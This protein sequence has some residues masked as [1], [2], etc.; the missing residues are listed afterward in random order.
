MN[1]TN[2]LTVMTALSL[3][4]SATS[5]Q[6]ANIQIPSL[7]F[8]ITSAGTYVLKGNLSYSGTS[9]AI[10]ISPNITGPVILNLNGFTITGIVSLV[11]VPVKNFSVAVGVLGAGT[12]VP[13]I[14][15]EN[16]V[17]Q[18][19]GFGLWVETGSVLSNINVNNMAFKFILSATADGV[20]ILFDEVN[21]S[22]VTNCTFTSSDKGIADGRSGGGN[23]YTNDSFTNDLDC[24]DISPGVATTV[25]NHCQVEEPSK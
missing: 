21:S 13:S 25:I 4:M 10:N 18:N 8:N 12:L 1:R 24:L 22:S 3:I 14:T 2:S 5:L 20:C 17:I 23:R 9:T 6:A 11:G 7:P 19:F 16:G 15:I